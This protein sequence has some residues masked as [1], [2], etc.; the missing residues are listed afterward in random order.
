MWDVDKFIDSSINLSGIYYVPAT[1]DKAFYRTLRN[2][3]FHF[4][5]TGCELDRLLVICFHFLLSKMRI[6][7]GI[8]FYLMW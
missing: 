2:L 5:A 6:E 8:Y 4:S 3:I 1:Y 7:Y